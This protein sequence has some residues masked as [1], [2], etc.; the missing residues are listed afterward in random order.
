MFDYPEN[1][2]EYVFNYNADRYNKSAYIDKHGSMTFGQL[3]DDSHAFAQ[4]LCMNG[5]GAGDFVMLALPNTK[6]FPVAFLGCI[7][8]GAVI[9]TVDPDLDKDS[10][11]NLANKTSAKCIV[12]TDTFHKISQVPV[13]ID[14]DQPVV[15]QSKITYHYY[16]PDDLVMLLCTSATTGEPKLVKHRSRLLFDIVELVRNSDF[17]ITDTSVVMC[18]SKISFGYSLTN[19]MIVA[20]STGATAIIFD[21]TISPTNV[22]NLVNEHQVTHLFASPP[23]YNLMLNKK[24]LQLPLHLRVLVCAGESLPRTLETNFKEKYKIP[25]FNVYGWSEMPWIAIV[26]DLKNHRVGSIGKALPGLQFKIL[27]PDGKDCAVG[28]PG[29]LFV[30][31][32]KTSNGYYSATESQNLAFADGWFKT[33][34]VVY[35]DQD[36]FYFFVNRNGLYVKINSTWTS[37]QEIEN[38]LWSTGKINDCTVVFD[39]TD[40]GIFEALAFVV[41]KEEIQTTNIVLQ[42]R[43]DLTKIAKSN[44]IP[45]KIYTLLALPRSKRNKR[46]ID[47]KI[48][49][50]AYFANRT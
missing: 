23:V 20:L 35:Q 42:L 46:I 14:I 43:S 41:I 50:E 15:Y 7:I 40:D 44:Q 30:H 47:K 24:D 8:V 6:Q 4:Q 5:I 29:V 27:D 16:D 18:T 1:Y 3:S 37:A 9:V 2:A 25:I 49:E 36:G 21:S 19:N 26:N 11:A 31:T 45:K 10:V 33:D 34:D 32:S 12:S 39:K 17:N 22:I 48:L 13:F 28:V 38:L